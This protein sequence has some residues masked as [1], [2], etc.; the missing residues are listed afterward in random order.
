MRG[1]GVWLFDPQGN[2]YLD[3]YN[4]VASVGHAQPDVVEA[5]GR[6]WG[7]LN[8]TTPA[9]LHE[10]VLDYAEAL[11]GTLPPH[12]GHMMFTC[13]GS[14]ANDLAY[15]IAKA[16]TGRHRHD[17]HGTGLSR[18]YR[19]RVAVLAFA[20]CGRGRPACEDRTRTRRGAAPCWR[21]RPCLGARRQG[22]DRRARGLRHRVRRHDLRH[23]SS[24]ATA[25]SP[26]PPGFLAEAAGIVRAAGGLFIADE[27][28]AGF[29]RTG[30]ALWG[31]LRH[32]L[33]PDMVTLGKPM[34]NGPADR[35]CRGEARPRRRFRPANP[36]FQHVRRQPG[37]G[38]RRARG[39]A[40]DPARR[41]PGQCPR[42]RSLSHGEIG[43]A[44]RPPSRD[45]ARSA[46][47][48]STWESSSSRTADHASPPR[49]LQPGWST[50]FDTGA[51]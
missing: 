19:C 29:G 45:P 51:C 26:T 48:V 38:R 37:F 39:A 49:L 20:R 30:D 3:A 31:F 12:L 9:T 44:C 36:L 42:G 46:A 5:V 17:R 50:A 23:R 6:Q 27:V 21:P 11:L 13:T 25:S 2:R 22:G 18:R 16:A 1:D 40:R 24:R 34:G 15:R 10:T 41:P 47:Q 4:N 14:E 28:Q 8:T 33:A 32:G 7:A 43:E 35:R